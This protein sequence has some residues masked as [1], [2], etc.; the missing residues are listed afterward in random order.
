MHT[1]VRALIVALLIGGSVFWVPTAATIAA[2]PFGDG[3]SS[4]RSPA[5]ADNDD[6]NDDD[7]NNEDDDNAADDNGN[8]NASSDD[9]GNDNYSDNDNDV[10]TSPSSDVPTD[11]SSVGANV[12]NGDLTIELWRSDERP[13]YNRSFMIAVKGDGAPI[14]RV[15]WWAEGPGGNGGDDLAHIGVQ[16]FDCGGSQPCNPNWTVVARNVGFYNIHARVRDT[17]GREV[18]TDWYVLVSENP[19]SG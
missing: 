2:T 19:R 16:S 9:N 6:N 15:W 13:V 5:L 8:D 14:E 7:D 17:S 18:Q 4:V 11:T 1:L 10:S 12:Q 3:S